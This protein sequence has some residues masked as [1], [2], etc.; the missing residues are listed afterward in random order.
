MALDKILVRAPQSPERLAARNMTGRYLVTYRTGAGDHVAMKLQEIGIAAAP[1]VPAGQ[2]VAKAL[3]DSSQINLQQLGIALVDPMPAQEDSFHNIGATEDSILA[4]E[5]ERVNRAVNQDLGSDYISG[6]RDAI[7]SLTS[8]LL[9]NERFPRTTE[10]LTAATQGMTWGLTAIGASNT[11]LSGTNIRLAILDTGFD[12]SHPDFAHRTIVTKNYVGDQQ[13]FHDGVGHGT[14]CA[15]TAVGPLTSQGGVRFGV[16]ANCVLYVGRVLDDTGHGGDF[17]ILQGI[18]W[19]IA[20]HC[21]I[22]SLSLGA[23][24]F[25]GDPTYIQ[26]YETAAQN[27]LRAGCLLVIAAG[28]EADK[29]LYVGA[30]GTPGNSPSMLTV[31]AVDE[32]LATASFSNRV[33]PQAPGVKGPDIAAPGVEVYSSWLVKAGTYKKDSGTS[34]ATPHVAGIAAMLAEANPAVRGQALKDLVLANCKALPN[35]A[36]RVGEIGRGLVQAPIGSTPRVAEESISRP[37]KRGISR[38]T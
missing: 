18:N 34:M 9:N 31:A 35:G 8:K 22:I 5:P 3:P 17:N 19:A 16:S 15:G 38:R 26:A 24:W 28:N 1:P 13:P 7:E 4:I 32:N 11:K 20:E 12:S 36:M 37:S 25:P 33:R 2:S 29:P 6:W 10:S 23:P 30:V 27:A 21:D 14:H